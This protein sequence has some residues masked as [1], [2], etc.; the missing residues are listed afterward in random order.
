MGCAYQGRVHTQLMDIAPS[1]FGL[2]EHQEHQEYRA[3]EVEPTFPRT[4]R[5]NTLSLNINEFEELVSS[6]RL[7]GVLASVPASPQSQVRPPPLRVV[8]R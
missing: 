5:Q 6:S 3:K 2:S 8:L 4:G 7:R 1:P